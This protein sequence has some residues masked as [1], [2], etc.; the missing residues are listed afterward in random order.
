VPL[1]VASLGGV[2]YAYGLGVFAIG[3]LGAAVGEARIDVTTAAPFVF[4]GGLVCGAG[5][6]GLVLGWGR[7]AG[8]LPL[9]SHRSILAALVLSGVV[10]LLCIVGYLFAEPRSDVVGVFLLGGLGLYGTL[11]AVAWARGG[12]AGLLNRHT[13]GLDARAARGL[14]WG[15]AGAFGILGLAAL[16]GLA[17]QLFGVENPQADSFD[18]LSGRPIAQYVAAGLG[19]AVIAPLA[20]EIF[21]R[22]YVFNAY[23][24]AKGPR[25]AY[26]GSALVFASVHLLPTLL[27]TFF[28]IGL[29]LAFIYRRTG[30]IVAP[31]V[32]HT[33]NNSTAFFALIQALAE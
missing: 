4:G 3:S 8:P 1:L 20:E 9:G 7:V 25:T 19:V 22:G 29:V 28:L 5:L 12:R 2:V 33:I 21:F 17:L 6:V 23:L 16:N 10:A 15:V 26:L 11:V 30:S 31:I 32:A 27:P 18:W 24:A 14:G 13:L